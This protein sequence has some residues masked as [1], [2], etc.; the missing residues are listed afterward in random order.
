MSPLTPGEWQAIWLTAKLAGL[1]TFI[2]LL[3][4]APLAWWLAH[5]KSRMSNLAAALVSLPLVLPPTVIGFYLLLVLG[6]QGAVGGTLEAL[7][8]HHLAFSFWGILIGSL[9]YSLPFAVQ[10]L[11]EAFAGIDLRLLDAAATL[12]AGP[13]DRFFSVVLPLSRSGILTA[14]V[15]TFAHTVG[16]FGV[17]AMLGGSI[18]GETKVVSIAI[19]DYTQALEYG[20]AHRLSAILLAFSFAT[21]LLFYAINQR[22]MSP[23][24]PR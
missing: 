4:S 16:E 17:I 22:V 18:A 21:L 2:L 13:M 10:P 9:I 19:Y 23:L 7:G 15:I 6:P 14:V 24:K 8:L 12:R 1:T 11:R 20:A 3:I 5:S